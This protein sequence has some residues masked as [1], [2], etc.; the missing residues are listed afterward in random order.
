M[1]SIEQQIMSCSS[2][3]NPTPDDGVRLRHLIG[4]A[5]DRGR[6]VDRA[7][8]EGLAGLFYK[9]LRKA[10]LL[11][12]LNDAQREKLRR[13]YYRTVHTNLRRNHDVQ[14]VLRHTNTEKIPVV[15]LK[16]I[17]LL[18]QVYQ[19]IG[20]REMTDIDLWVLKKNCPGLIQILIS[21]G[22]VRD[23]VYPGTFRKGAT[24]FD[25]HAHFLGADR[26][27]ARK[28]LL[29]R[30]QEHVYHNTR[31]VSFGG[32]TALCLNPYDQVL[33]LGLHALK[34]NVSQLIWLVDIRGLVIDWQASDWKTLTARAQEMAQEKTLVYIFYLLHHLLGFHPPGI[35]GRLLHDHRLNALEKMVLKQRTTKDGLPAWAPLLLFA[36][37]K[38]LKQRVWFIFESVFPRPEILRQIFVHKRHSRAWQLYLLRAAQLANK[39]L[40]YITRKIMSLFSI[41]HLG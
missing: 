17:V 10:G 8:K 3:L 15:L 32:H 31:V 14:Q 39:V 26:I 1:I 25:L 23:P 16:G 22:Y 2:G 9:N 19:D 27:E 13:H 41:S 36:P 35:A 29:K 5:K 37:R 24:T 28:L 18:D 33:Y 11:D 21:Q 40:S 34:H 30:S 4:L 12:T 6:L 7:F 38:G 20:L